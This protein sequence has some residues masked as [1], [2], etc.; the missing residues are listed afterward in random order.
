MNIRKT[1]SEVNLSGTMTV[2][3]TIMMILF[4]I[5]IAIEQIIQ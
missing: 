4:W 1:R 2:V 5:A 3:S